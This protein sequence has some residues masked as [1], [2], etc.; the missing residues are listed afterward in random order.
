MDIA[1]RSALHYR[2]L[3]EIGI[4]VWK[5]IDVLIAAFCIQNDF[6][7]LHNDRDFDAMVNLLGLKVYLTE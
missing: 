2:S 3:S 5:T 7:L 6:K 1:L 4:I